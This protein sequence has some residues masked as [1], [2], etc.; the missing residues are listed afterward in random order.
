[1]RWFHS[2]PEYKEESQLAFEQTK[3][4]TLDVTGYLPDDEYDE[5]LRENMEGAKRRVVRKYIE[6]GRE[7]EVPSIVLQAY[8]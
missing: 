3:L 7:H 1:M 2:T 5:L 8:R 6:S 4:W